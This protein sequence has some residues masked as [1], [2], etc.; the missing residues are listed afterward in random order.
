[1]CFTF[2]AI[3]WGC[4]ALLYFHLAHWL[5]KKN[6]TSFSEKKPFGGKKIILNAADVRVGR[7]WLKYYCGHLIF[8]MQRS[9]RKSISRN[10]AALR[11]GHDEHDDESI[12]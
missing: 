2:C 5:P 7:A 9:L 10:L 8:A 1:M 4:N 6:K 3:L 12:R 11:E